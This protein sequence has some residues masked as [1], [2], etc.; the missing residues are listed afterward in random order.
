MGS[1]FIIAPRFACRP[2]RGRREDRRAFRRL[3][4]RTALRP[5][6]PCAAPSVD[7]RSCA[8]PFASR[9]YTQESEPRSD[10]SGARN[11]DRLLRAG[12]QTP[13]FH[14]C[15]RAVVRRGGKIDLDQE[16]VTRWI[17]G[18]NDLRHGA[19][20]AAL[21]TRRRSSPAPSSPCEWRQ[22]PTHPPWPQVATTQPG[23]SEAAARQARPWFPDRPCAP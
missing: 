12:W 5:S 20:Q 15:R 1:L 21:A 22:S 9:T 7:E 6:S 16:A 4:C 13:P 18:R 14:T 2:D 10:H 11:E 8:I 3:K 23:R 17:G 19:R